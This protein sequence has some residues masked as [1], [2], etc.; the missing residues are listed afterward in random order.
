MVVRPDPKPINARFMIYKR[1]F[2]FDAPLT[3]A[4][5]LHE[6]RDIR[7]RLDAK[8]ESYILA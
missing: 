5:A 6:R 1:A 2:F 7:F 8:R 4:R 3:R